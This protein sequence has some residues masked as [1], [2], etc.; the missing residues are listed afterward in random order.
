MGICYQ[1]LKINSDAKK[2]FTK[3]IKTLPKYINPRVSRMNILK[4]EGNYYQALED[5]KK[6]Y[7]L[8]PNYLYPGLKKLIIEL[9]ML[10]KWK[11]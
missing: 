2:E 6:I 1:K 7:E 8:N 4:I 10:N 9:E 11:K 3:A 5:A